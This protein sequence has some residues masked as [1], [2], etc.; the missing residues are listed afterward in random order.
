MMLVQF[1]S[2]EIPLETDKECWK[3]HNKSN[4]WRMQPQQQS[5]DG[6]QSILLLF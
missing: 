2:P 1:T 6:I 3:F 5:R 4:G